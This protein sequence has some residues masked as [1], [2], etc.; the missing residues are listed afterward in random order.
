MLPHITIRNPHPSLDAEYTIT[1][2]ENVA[3]INRLILEIVTADRPTVGLV[4]IVIM[5]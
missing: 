3:S 2:N 1:A 5:G 4:P